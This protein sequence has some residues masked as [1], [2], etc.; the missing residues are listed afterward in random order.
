MLEV[1]SE[2]TGYPAEMLDLDMEIEADLGIDSIK[3]VEILGTMMD[4]YPDLPEINPEEL[5]ELRTLRQIADHIKSELSSGG[6]VAQPMAV[7]APVATG[8]DIE[9]LTKTMLEVVS[10]K[11][12]YPAEM[13]DLDMEIEADLGIDSIK[14]VEILG[15]MMDI[16]PDLPEINPEEL[17]ELRTLRQIADH[18]KSE[19]SSGG[20]VAQS[21]V[22]EESLDPI[23][24]TTLTKPKPSDALPLAH[25]ELEG[26]TRSVLA[27]VGENTGYPAEML[28]LDMELETELGVDRIKLIEMFRVLREQYPTLRDIDHTELTE[29]RTL[30]DLVVYTRKLVPFEESPRTEARPQESPVEGS[31]SQSFA[32]LKHL[33]AP[34]FLEFNLPDNHICLL[35]DDGTSATVE[36]AESL[37]GG[38]WKVV[39]LSFPTSLIRERLPLSQGIH[40][41]TLEDL[42]EVHL[43]ETLQNISSDFGPIGGFIHMNPPHELDPSDGILPSEAGKTLLLHVFLSA[44]HLKASLTQTNPPGRRFFVTVARMNG[45]LGVGE[46]EFNIV[47]G[48]LFG[49][50]KTLNL[51]WESV[52]CRAIDLSPDLDTDQVVSTIWAELHDPDRRI[53]ETGYG[54]QGRVTLVPEALDMA[55]PSQDHCGIDSSSVFLVS[56]GARGVTAECVV[57]LAS[58]C[59]GKYIL[60]GRS[61]FTG[62]EPEWA[63]DCF[64]EAE[65]RKRGM[66][67]L[68]SQGEKPTPM[69]VQELLKPVLANREIT[70]TLTAIRE[71]GGE[72]E[73][74]SVD[75]TDAE[76]LQQVAP[77]TER[78]GPI[79]GIIHG[80]GVLADK[81]IEKKTIDDLEA[82]YSTKVKGLEALLSCVDTDKLKYLILFS[83]AAGFFGN[84]GQSDYAIANEILNKTAHKFKHKHPDCHVVSFN[85]GP[86]DGGMVTDSLKRMF[87]ERGIQVI[88]VDGGAQVFV[89]RLTIGD[90]SPQILVGSSMLVEG[91]EVDP[92]LRTYRVVR[93]LDLE[94][95][96]FLPD[97]SIGG[98]PVLPAACVIL[99]MGDVCE[100]LY[101]GY[102]AFR[103]DNFKTLKGIVFDET[104]AHE[105]IMD[106]R[107]LRKTNLGEI[108]FDIE[109]S[110]RHP[111]DK[112]I[113]HY[114]AQILLLSKTP[115]TPVYEHFDRTEHNTMDGMSLYQDGTLFHGS[116]FQAITRVINI[117]STKLTMEC[118]TP[119]IGERG[120]GQFPIRAF[121]PYAADAQFQSML[122]WVRNQFDAGSLPSKARS[123]EQYRPVPTD[124]TFYVSLD[125]ISSTRTS[126]VADITTHDE[127]GNIYTRVFGAEVTISKNLNQLFAKVE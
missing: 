28:E 39:V 53:V 88:P 109:I 54:S 65:L 71:A 24:T 46:G 52:F 8:P 3:R 19:L 103:C 86:W 30:E 78:F 38:G 81:M 34:D 85:W 29:L 84:P 15:T 126:M 115:D 58:K 93:K 111:Q 104:L 57:R 112:P 124:R 102:K 76:A 47:D 116:H 60:L 123:G 33:P 101:P 36:L 119:E 50:T 25:V 70:R 61:T 79:T 68:N 59:H 96:P 21:V 114:S 108:E 56:G 13:L 14:R 117:S 113:H 20:Q 45:T 99:W 18:I 69:K 48:G 107:E 51:E 110:S 63:R 62:E 118:R 75:V 42:S 23:V 98:K 105:Y 94:S 97:H 2:K 12:G 6:Q 77:I 9:A 16:Y 10:E 106:L 92:E 35:T 91:G 121:N 100:Q 127:M 11:T 95:N 40:R 17:V 41:I 37:M 32:R 7:T 82:V 83:S 67:V 73:Y 44:K 1:V 4:I 89:D 125:I 64:D 122:I 22:T 90:S 49:L 87:T 120:Q 43:E 27:V 74:V 66:D 55:P 31:I 5:V 26:F 72:A 80:A